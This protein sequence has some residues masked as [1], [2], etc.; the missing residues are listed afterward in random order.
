[1]KRITAPP[2]PAAA[3]AAIEEEEEDDVEV[4]AEAEELDESP[5]WKWPFTLSVLVV[6]EDGS[7]TKKL[8]VGAV[9]VEGVEV[10]VVWGSGVP[11]TKK[12]WI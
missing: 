2:A 8:V 9:E 1:M 4:E 12:L 7:L 11:Q 6:E 5:R 3:I 10:V